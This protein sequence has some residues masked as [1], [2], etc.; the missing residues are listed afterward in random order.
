MRLFYTHPQINICIKPQPAIF[1]L[2]KHAICFHKLPAQTMLVDWILSGI[3]TSKL[4][5]RES[6]LPQPSPCRF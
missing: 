6:E 4:I 5:I 1:P 3:I 2:S